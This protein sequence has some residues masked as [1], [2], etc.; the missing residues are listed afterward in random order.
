MA[1]DGPDQLVVQR[2][3]GGGRAERAVAHA[4]PGAPGDLR[5]FGRGEAAGAVAVELVE[6]GEGDV[7]DVHV[8]A[9]AD[10]V[11]G[12]EEVDLFVLIKLHLRIAR[13]WRQPA[14]DDRASATA[15]TDQLGDRVNLTGAE[16]HDGRSG[17]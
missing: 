2:R 10:R 1:L 12:D 7:I 3:A 13:P 16:G 4:A 11:G 17:R 9:H 6:P 5:D 14:H 15:P 8:E